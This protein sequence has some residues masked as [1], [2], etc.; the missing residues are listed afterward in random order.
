MVYLVIK[1]LKVDSDSS[2]I[3]VSCLSKDMTSDVDLFRANAIRVLAKVMD[4]SSLNAIDCVFAG[5]NGWAD[6]ALPQT[7]H[8]R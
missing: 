4:V 6:R 5:G 7:S 8:R 1:D 3:V 2:L